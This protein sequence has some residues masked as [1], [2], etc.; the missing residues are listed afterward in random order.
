MGGFFN[1]GNGSAGQVV[2]GLASG[3]AAELYAIVSDLSHIAQADVQ[4]VYNDVASVAVWNADVAQTQ[5]GIF[6]ELWGW[7]KN[8]LW[9]TLWGWI[10]DLRRWLY[11]FFKPL[12]DVLN[13]MKKAQDAYYKQVLK[14]VLVMLQKIRSILVIFRVFG[15][16][17]AVSLDQYLAGREALISKAFLQTRQELN[18]LADWID[19]TINLGGLLNEGMFIWSAIQS[20]SQLAGALWG[21][22]NNPLGAQQIADMKAGS[23]E[24]IA[25]NAIPS[26][27]QAWMGVQPSTWTVSYT[28]SVKQFQDD[29]WNPWGKS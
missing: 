3:V 18:T 22:S 26:A 19:W 23:Q 17:W 29:G 27:K 25:A 13:Q 2:S 15:L 10:T 11:H 14:P 1:I 8:S 9:P 7:L 6:S 12:I 5:G 4:A 28:D 20:I 16:K 21:Q 24:G